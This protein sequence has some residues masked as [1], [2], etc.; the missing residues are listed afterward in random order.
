MALYLSLDGG[1]A[2]SVGDRRAKQ[3]AL[4]S[5]L[6]IIAAVTVLAMA[7]ESRLTPEQH[8]QDFVETPTYP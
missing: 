3:R 4:I 5:A 7:V 2:T 1:G 8:V 6:L